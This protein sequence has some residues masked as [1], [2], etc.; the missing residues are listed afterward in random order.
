MSSNS[1]ATSGTVHRGNGARATEFV[2]KRRWPCGP[3]RSEHLPD[4]ERI[5][6]AD[7]VR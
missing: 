6:D 3:P 4:P 2:G 5:F 7:S 1:N